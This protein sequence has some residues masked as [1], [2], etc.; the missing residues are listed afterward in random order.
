LT[1]L[2][3]L[4]VSWYDWTIVAPRRRNQRLTR[5]EWRHLFL[6]TLRLQSMTI[7]KLCKGAGV[8][9]GRFYQLRRELARESLALGELTESEKLL[10]VEQ[11]ILTPE[12]I[13]V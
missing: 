8:T 1:I 7:G 6:A 3:K 5:A 12:E 2:Y 11:E 13:H 9:R 4:G 10:C